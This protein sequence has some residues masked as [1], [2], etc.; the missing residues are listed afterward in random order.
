MECPSCHHISDEALFKC[1]ACG[2]TYERVQLEAAQHLDYL[3]TWLDEQAEVLG[4]QMH[5]FLRDEALS[6]LDELHRSLHLPSRKKPTPAATPPV[7]VIPAPPV[8]VMRPPAEVAGELLRVTAVLKQLRGWCEQAGLSSD[9]ADSLGQYFTAQAKS[10]KLELAAPPVDIKLPS[11]L[12]TFEYA[13]EALPDWAEALHLEP[14][15]V[16]RL[17]RYL[18]QQRL[19]LL[20]PEP[21]L[22]AAPTLPPQSP[23]PV[24]AQSPSEITQDLAPVEE[25]HPPVPVTSS[26]PAT[27]PTP[28]PGPIATPVPE[29][30]PRP[31]SPPPGIK[32]ASLPP[33]P[34]RPER[35][36]APPKPKRPPINWGKI[37]EK[38]VEAFVS[39]A[40]L[41]GLLY[42]GGLMIVVSALVL[43][44]VYWEL[45]PLVLKLGFIAAVPASFYAG[46]Y[47]LQTRVKTPVAAGVFTGIGALLVAVDFAAVYQ[48][49][50]LA[51]QVDINAYWLMA[52]VVCTTIYI[53]TV[54]RLPHEFFGYITLAGLSSIVLALTQVLGLPPEWEIASLS[55][56]GV[57]MVAGSARLERAAERWRELARAARRLPQ[58]LLPLTLALAIVLGLFVP[59]DES[60]GQTII[61]LLAAVGYGLLAWYFPSAIFAHA[62]IWSSIGAAGFAFQAGTLRYEWLATAAAVLAPA[63]ILG[64]RWLEQTWSE[65][66]GPRRSY[67]MA[68][69]LAGFGLLA[70]AICGGLVVLLINLWAGV[71]AL[72][73]AA[74]VLVGCAYLYRRPVLGLLA[75]GLFIIP[76]SLAVFQWLSDFNVFQPGAW[77]MG[78]WAGL[79][80]AYLGLAAFLRQAEKYVTWLN[81]WAHL[82]APTAAIGLLIN[83]SLTAA[84]WFSG[85]TLAALAGL[86]LLYLVSAVLHDSGRHLALSDNLKWLPA[87]LEPGI[88]LWPPGC[89]L[90]VWLAVAWWS[91]PLDRP[92]L[93]AALAG[94]ALVYVGL[95]QRLARRC[96]AYRLPLHSYAYG[97]AALSIVPAFG[98]TWALLITLCVAVSVMGSLA[99][100]Y[101]RVWEVAMAGLLFLWPFHLALGLSPLTPHTYTLA[102]SLLAT[103]GYVP[104]GLALHQKGGRAYALPLYAIGY[105]LAAGAVVASLFG[106]FELYPRNVPWVGV[107]TP[108]LITGLLVFSL[109]RFR[110]RPFAWAAALVG[111][112]AFGQALTLGRVPSEFDAAAWVGLALAY[113]LTERILARRATSVEPAVS[114][115]YAL[116]E[117]LAWFQGFRW[118]LS[119]GTVLLSMLGLLLI[120]PE[121]VI[122]FS[123]GHVDHFAP[124]ILAQSLVVGLTVLAARLYRSRLPLLL[125]PWLAFVPVTLLFMGYGETIIGQT[126]TMAQYGLVWSG[127]G[128]VHLLAAVWLDRAK[129]RYAHGLYLGGYLLSGLAIISTLFAIDRLPLLWTLGLWILAAAGSALLVQVNRHRTWDEVIEILFGPEQST[130]RSIG[131]GTFL[132]LAAF[133]FPLWCMLLLRQ[134]HVSD[135][136]EW[137]GF[138]VPA[139]IFLALGVWLRHFE[140]T[141]AWPFYTA[142][143]VYTAAG[144]LLSLPATLSLLTDRLLVGTS[145]VTD[146]RALAFIVLQTLAVGFYVVSARL[147]RRGFLAHLAAWLSFCPYT[148]AWVVYAP[149]LTPA[150]FG[151]VWSGLGL[152]HLLAAVWL[153]RIKVRYAHGPFLT[154]YTLLVLAIGW[155]VVWRDTTALVWTLGLGLLVAAGSAWLVQ[156]NRHHTWDE[157]IGLLF[158]SEQSTLRSV[159]RGAFM[160]LAAWPFPLWCMLL[161]WQLHVSDGFEWL[162]FGVPALLFLVLGMW[163]RRFERTY[164]WPFYA[165]AQVYTAA[166]LL[167]SLPATLSLL[168]D[169]LLAG[170]PAVTDHRALAFIV[171]QTL[172]VGF[173]AA[174]ARLFWRGSLAHLAAW[175]SFCP[176]TLAWV[177]FAPGLITVRFA[178]PWIGLAAAL[179]GLG[180]V[181]ERAQVRHPRPGFKAAHGPYLAGYMLAGLALVWS[182]PDRLT[183]LYTLAAA[184]GLAVASQLL[185]HSGRHGAFEDM[186][187]FIWRKPGTVAHRAARTAFLFFV[188]YACPVWLAQL[189]TYH[190]VPLAWRGAALALAAPIYIAGGLALRRIKTEYTWPLYSAG[191]ALTAVGAMVAFA[192]ERLAIYVLVLNAVVYA[193]S[194]YIF[195][196]SFWLYLSTILIPV[197]AL[198]GVHYRFE[199]LPVPWVAGIFMGLAFL[200]TGLGWG[201][202][203]FSRDRTPAAG[204]AAFALPWYGPGYLLSA[205]ALAVAASGG[206]TL[207]F[208]VYSAGVV[209]YA[210]SAWSLRE[211]IFLYPAAWLAAVPYYLALTSTPLSPAWYGLG[212]LPLIV[213]Y[214][215]LGRFW[216]DRIKPLDPE[217]GTQADLSM[218]STL[219]PLQAL[220]GLFKHGLT[221]PAMPFYLLAYGLSVSMI[222]I[223]QRDPL[224]LTLAFAASG[225]VY[226][227]SAVLFR[228]VIW[229]YPGLLATHLALPIAFT[230]RPTGWPV[231]YVSLPL[232]G[233]TW[234]MALCGYWL[235]HRQTGLNNVDGSTFT[236]TLRSWKSELDRWPGLVHFATSSWAQPFFI[237]TVLDLVLSQAVALFNLETA[238]IVATGLAA[239]LGLFAMLWLDGALV[240]GALIFFILAVGYRLYWTGLPLAEAV[241][242]LGGIGFGLYLLARLVEQ[243]AAGLTR[244]RRRLLM[245]PAPLTHLAVFLTT[246]AVVVTLPLIVGHFTAGAAA[247]A[248]AGALY[249]T[250]AY[251]GRYHRLGYLGMA[252]LLAAWVLVLL[253]WDITQPQWYAIPTGLYFTGIGFLERRRASALQNPTRLL[254]AILVES[255]GLAVLLLTSFIQSLDSTT[256]F[257][258]FVLLLIE[259]LLVTW[260]GAGRRLRLPFFIGLGASALNVVA[261]VVVVINVYEVD[262]WLIIFGVGLLLVTLA[263][264]V[265][266]QRLRVIAQAQVWRE[267]L[268]TWQ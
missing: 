118:P 50:G 121:T 99:V 65:E 234:V 216:F 12:H 202:N 134:L 11:D 247:L 217:E 126:L 208:I 47:V 207:V 199:A 9:T 82:L 209:L 152:V 87:E 155:T 156:V 109:Y 181:L 32:P 27:A 55:G 45:F 119:L 20:Q 236:L 157:L 60:P 15:D 235:S 154:G 74:L 169:R 64:G 131:R 88:F 102:Y 43:V 103:L 29:T 89:L 251:R 223:S 246:M 108:L 218:T 80:L 104:L 260:W 142:A 178:W 91:S 239:L 215:A 176:Y 81:L 166:G 225:A 267:A 19:A 28:K 18:E 73:L 248:F 206:R 70:I 175:L 242:T 125:E 24:I 6:Q 49:A 252:M 268:E 128:L 255:F 110:Q 237:F 159:G 71:L 266:R 196:Q 90:P 86:I 256:G 57:A 165:A 219:S 232:L 37:W 191:Y 201:F 117:G 123:G 44:V 263:V 66:T 141:Y 183:N 84:T 85:P 197:I 106:R 171:L 2:E 40:L 262:R 138:G 187:Q 33:P 77:L 23:P 132:W 244:Q 226:L 190:D 205:L 174:S 14:A 124:L 101:C 162:G 160:W 56:A 69:A 168:A 161:L 83:Y 31:A 150:Q 112:I 204:L 144:L 153:D 68:A 78:A 253:R 98:E 107:V 136:F 158:G 250:M 135:G 16:E 5:T 241:A 13:C 127:L 211:M 249:L 62:S 147:F 42:L 213:G 188:A 111:P 120:L 214:I 203:R 259:A 137:L 94:L 140:R 25:T 198:L 75:S 145:V 170:T 58:L 61:F 4:V 184:I 92:W 220:A 185:V 7:E 116:P 76:F 53:V 245:W 3:V 22:P 96:E 100:V 51:G 194:A 36:P 258:Y 186:I 139:L 264:F 172:T 97:L 95:G 182:T 39:G 195:R 265:E 230:I 164:A 224:A 200:Y 163:L 228:R 257:P 243:V 143:Q 233:M 1:S 113:L 30:A 167:L 227:A 46:G 148:L 35:P 48:L 8:V 105:L 63:Y 261:Q 115:T 254:F 67:P 130:L 173:Y 17:G 151:L 193:V 72:T 210:L 189:L 229:L 222:V 59:G 34:S 133:P 240:G 54:W 122:A 179:L 212:W 231:P 26:I 180:F 21:E 79:G 52:S 221:R 38:T 41:R 149:D 238:I 93:G 114:L 10:L 177:V 129:V 146:H 192:D